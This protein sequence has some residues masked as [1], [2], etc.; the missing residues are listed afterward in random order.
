MRLGTV[1][2]PLL[3]VSSLGCEPPP[4]NCDE[5]PRAQTLP[6]TLLSV[7]GV[8]LEAE[9]AATPVERDRGWMHRRCDREALL[10]VLDEAG[11]LPVWGC[12][13]TA[14]ID[15]AWIADERVIAVDTLEP[16]PAPCTRCPIVGDEI[17]TEA[18]LEIPR[19]SV[20]LSAGMAATW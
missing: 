18:V 15:V 16:C 14:A 12:G 1:V 7:G 8:A 13:L 4:P 11:P 17:T 5:D 20:P 10:L 6:T 9:V 19:D 2:A 3:V